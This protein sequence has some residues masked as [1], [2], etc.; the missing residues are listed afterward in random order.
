MIR[1]S[2]DLECTQY[3][4]SQIHIV[5]LDDDGVLVLI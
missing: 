2:P 3:V 5:S 4:D 1:T